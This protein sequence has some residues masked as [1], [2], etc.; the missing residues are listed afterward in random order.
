MRIIGCV[1]ELPVRQQYY[2]R[3]EHCPV[4]GMLLGAEVN[5]ELLLKFKYPRS[6]LLAYRRARKASS[7]R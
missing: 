5:L 3:K 6:K 4:L 7:N 1:P 2:N